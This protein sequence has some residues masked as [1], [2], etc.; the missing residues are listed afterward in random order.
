MVLLLQVL[1]TI[2]SLNKMR[3]ARTSD[4]QLVLAFLLT[5]M[6]KG[7]CTVIDIAQTATVIG[8]WRSTISNPNQRVQMI[9]LEVVKHIEKRACMCIREQTLTARQFASILWM[10]G[11]LGIQPES[12]EFRDLMCV[13]MKEQVRACLCLCC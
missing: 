5:K 4:L 10:F 2:Q 11:R 1:H 6:Q 9:T 8:R 3:M 13:Y 12:Q 7:Q